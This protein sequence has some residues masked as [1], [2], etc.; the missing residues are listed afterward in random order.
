MYLKKEVLLFIL[1]ILNVS[2][3]AIANELENTKKEKEIKNDEANNEIILRKDTEEN[4]ESVAL[5]NETLKQSSEVVSSKN[6]KEEIKPI[7]KDKKN[8]EGFFWEDKE[9]LIKKDINIED[10]ANILIK[11][12]K[13]KSNNTENLKES[14]YVYGDAGGLIFSDFSKLNSFLSERNYNTVESQYLVLGSGRRTTFGRILQGSEVTF[15]VGNKN[16]V[17]QNGVIVNLNSNINANFNLGYI[18]Y[19][20]NGLHIFPSIGLGYQRLSI[21]I[22]KEDKTKKTTFEEVL[23]DPSNFST[24]VS[25]NTVMADLGLRAEYL[26]KF[27]ENK[28][29]QILNNIQSRI[30]IS[31]ILGIKTGYVIDLFSMDG[32]G[33]F[34]SG[35]LRNP[36]LGLGKGGGGGPKKGSEDSEP[37]QD[38]FPDLPEINSNGF[39]I[40]VYAGFSDNILVNT[41]D[42]L[43]EE[44]IKFFKEAFKNKKEENKVN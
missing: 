23:K 13:G 26:F 30:P 40:K 42:Y 12:P 43:K 15:L 20:K 36:L 10:V 2:N 17:A 22:S 27:P 16:T 19:A 34:V 21:D 1:I 28:E 37:P 39:Y 18:F 9:P 14:N 24:S 29:N 33:N 41:V 38:K 4:K 44:G 6:K 35:L 5:I 32:N 11:K 31:F 8:I 3:I 25:K 7:E